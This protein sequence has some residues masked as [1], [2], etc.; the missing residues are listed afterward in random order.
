MPNT[1]SKLRCKQFWAKREWKQIGLDNNTAR[2]RAQYDKKTQDRLAKIET[3]KLSFNEVNATKQQSENA[4]RYIPSN[5][6]HNLTFWIEHAS[7]TYCKKCNTILPSRLLPKFS[8]RPA[9]KEGSKTCPCK[10]KRYMQPK[11]SDIPDVLCG[12]TNSE[13][14]ALRPL[15]IHNGEYVR[16]ENGYRK[17]DSIFELSWS[18]KSVLE[19]IDEI[20]DAQSRQRCINAYNYLM[21]E[22]RSS[23]KKFVDKRNKLAN[24]SG[25]HRDSTSTTV[26]KIGMSNVVCG[27][28]YIRP[29]N[30][31]RVASPEIQADAAGKYPSCTKYNRS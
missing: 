22:K 17:K 6:I 14:C 8:K 24:T 23:Y 4:Q 19:K 10:T 16:A 3:D 9:V 29:E 26:P 11:A 28:S 5:D 30:S 7:Y 21:N 27:H 18:R 15:T 13:I 12:L 2:R 25:V 20:A 31:A 1:W